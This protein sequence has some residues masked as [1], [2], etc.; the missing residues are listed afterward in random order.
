MESVSKAFAAETV[1]ADVDLEVA[2]GEFMAILGPSGSGKS[3]LLR[4]IAGLESPDEGVVS[5]D[6]LPVGPPGTNP[7]AMVFEDAALYE[8]LDVGGNQIGRAHV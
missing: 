3:T 4:L 7:V 1:L 5:I 6:D 2:A 8:H